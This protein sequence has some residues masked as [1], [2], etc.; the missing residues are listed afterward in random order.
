MRKLIESFHV[1][2]FVGGGGGGG[3]QTM[4]R[5]F[6]GKPAHKCNRGNSS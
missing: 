2:D 5:F 4:L 3:H 1:D 6:M